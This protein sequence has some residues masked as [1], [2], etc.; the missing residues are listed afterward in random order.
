MESPP[1]ADP[2]AGGVAPN[3]ETGLAGAGPETEKPPNGA[4]ATEDAPV[5]NAEGAVDWAAPKVGGAAD[6]LAPNGDDPVPNADAAGVAPNEAADP[7][8]PGAAVGAEEAT[9]NVPVFDGA[10]AEDGADD[11]KAPEKPEAFVWPNMPGCWGAVLLPAPNMPL[12]PVDGCPNGVAPPNA[13]GWLAAAPP[14]P[15]PPDMADPNGAGVAE[16]AAAGVA[17]LAPNPEPNDPNPLDWPNG[18]GVAGVFAGCWPNPVAPKLLVPNP[19]GACVCGVLNA[20]NP[21]PKAVD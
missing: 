18:A 9:P 3:V 12:P 8:A 7:K 17:V 6:A 5:P 1:K 11:P 4:G 10:K 20:P 14:A 19:L 13:D 16:G 2:V 21:V 15:K